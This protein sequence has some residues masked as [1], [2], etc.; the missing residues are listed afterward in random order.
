MSMTDEQSVPRYTADDVFRRFVFLYE[1][2]DA[3]VKAFNDT[4]HCRL[5]IDHL[6]LLNVAQ[7]TLDDIWRYKAYHLKDK[8]K[9][10]DAIKRAAYLTKWF[11]RLRPIYHQRILPADDPSGVDPN[12]LLDKQDI[13]LLANEAVAI[14]ISLVTLSSDIKVNEIRLDGEYFANLL[15]DLHYREMP[16]DALLHIY[17]NIRY[18]ARGHSLLI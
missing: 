4:H 11:M 12:T 9:R 8:N 10:S 13:T 7:S 6:A 2:C 1:R 14:H 17:D 18:I 16:E 5:S 3:Y 15:Y